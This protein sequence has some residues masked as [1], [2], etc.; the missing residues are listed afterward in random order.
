MQVEAVHQL[1]LA[2]SSSPKLFACVLGS[3]ISRAANV[4]TGW[5]IT[6][7]L[8]AKHA[9][10]LGESEAAA[11]DPAAWYAK[12]YGGEPDYSE[13]VSKLAPTPELRRNLLEPYFTVLDPVSGERHE[14]PP[15][16]AHRAIAQLV[17]RGL[18][19]VI[20]TTNFDRLME[21]ALREAGVASIE[22]VS[23]DDQAAN[24]YPFHA[25]ECFVFKVHGDWKDTGLRNSSVELAAYPRGIAKLLRRIVNEHGLIVCGW[26]AE[27]DVALRSTIA[28]YQ[29]RFP[30]FWADPKLGDHAR[31]LVTQVRG[32]HVAAT[33]DD[34]FSE[35]ELGVGALDRQRPPPP[36]S[37]D[38]L[39]ARARRLI[40][41]QREMELDDLVQDATRALCGWIEQECDAT[42]PPDIAGSAISTRALEFASTCEAHAAP[43]ARLLTT[44]ARYKQASYLS[45]RSLSALL[46]SAETRAAPLRANDE[47]WWWLLSYPALLCAYAY[48][49][50]CA[51]K[52]EW[53]AAITAVRDAGSGHV[54]RELRLPPENQEHF[55][56]QLFA[57]TSRPSRLLRFANRIADWLFPLTEAWIPR[58]IEFDRAFDR[59]DV[60]LCTMTLR[61]GR[62]EW[63]PRVSVPREPLEPASTRCSFDDV[64]E[65][66]LINRLDRVERGATDEPLA[67][68]FDDNDDENILERMRKWNPTV[69]RT[70]PSGTRTRLEWEE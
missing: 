66:W 33:G 9:A 40:H 25:C 22:V 37:G 47:G 60:L 20:V 15:T 70:R 28:R 56:E 41:E 53:S 26:S 64:V 49:V 10:Q 54:V 24:C 32:T 67:A 44:L 19:R 29:R 11:K 61:S 51:D 57:G 17:K 58:R 35:L 14:H 23:S 18:V 34:F 69:Q 52:D 48:G 13:V 65:S 4:R 21:N 30:L 5:E 50:A 46:R 16:E 42:Y 27:Y 62:E 38:V 39:V 63:K 36:L 1:A 59:F 2:L 3:G 6:L 68:V 7:D 12:K 43:L 45:Q 55:Y 31:A 8:V